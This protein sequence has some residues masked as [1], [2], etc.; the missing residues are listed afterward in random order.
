LPITVTRCGRICFGRQK[1]NLSKVFAGQ[2]VGVKE[3]S[4]KIWLVSF[5]EYDLGFFEHETCQLESAENPFG[6]KVL[7]ISGINR[8]LCDR[9]GSSGNGGQ[10][11]TLGVV[12]INVGVSSRR[13]PD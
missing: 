2:N 7:P 13:S 1:I 11:V 5:M 10:G 12:S 4:D 6:A 8:Y 9:N 3:I